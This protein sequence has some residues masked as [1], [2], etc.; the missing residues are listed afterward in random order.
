MIDILA[1]LNDRTTRS[2]HAYDVCKSLKDVSINFPIDDVFNN[3]DQSP[4]LS[5]IVCEDK[6]PEC[7]AM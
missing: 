3:F 7:V 4:V 5:N 1:D 2:C 6:F